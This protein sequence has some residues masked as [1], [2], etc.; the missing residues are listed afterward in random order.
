LPLPA[1]RPET[2]QVTGVPHHVGFAPSQGLSV[3]QR[4]GSCEIAGSCLV[5][6]LIITASIV[7]LAL[8]FRDWLWYRHCR[9][10]EKRAVARGQ[11]PDALKMIK[12]AR[13]GS[14]R[15]L[16]ELFRLPLPHKPDE[17]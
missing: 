16:G 9:Y 8:V 4:L 6:P 12:A 17:K 3:T 15:R 7:G 5:E 1:G 11:N 13:K 14:L 10:V 2:S